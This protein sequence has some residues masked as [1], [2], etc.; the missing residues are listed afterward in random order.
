MISP[1]EREILARIELNLEKI[2]AVEFEID[3]TIFI[4]QMFLA[5]EKE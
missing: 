4:L 5:Y 3:D 2:N 1:P